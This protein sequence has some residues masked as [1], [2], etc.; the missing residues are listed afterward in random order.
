M[1]DH[2]HDCGERALLAW[3]A[4]DLAGSIRGDENGFVALGNVGTDVRTKDV[5]GSTA[6]LQNLRS[7]HPGYPDGRCVPRRS[8]C[9]GS[10]SPSS[11]DCS[12]H[13][14]GGFVV[15][16]CVAVRADVGGDGG[17]ELVGRRSQRK[18][19]TQLRDDH[20]PRRHPRRSRGHRDLTAGHRRTL[21]VTR[22]PY[23]VTVTAI[24]A[25]GS[26][27]PGTTSFEILDSCTRGIPCP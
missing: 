3:P 6:P 27:V 15:E 21:D 20:Q 24:N 18:P 14:G 8:L 9:P 23:A 12:V 17:G 16:G 19:D 26:S 10:W 11:A 7:S 1:G 5:R 25:N 22:P 2:E 4:D 13:C